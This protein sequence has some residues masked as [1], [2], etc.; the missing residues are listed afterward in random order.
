MLA[1]VKNITARLRF[2]VMNI[3]HSEPPR[4]KTG[5]GHSLHFR[6]AIY[7]CV[8]QL[9]IDDEAT[10]VVSSLG[11]DY[12]PPFQVDRIGEFWTDPALLK[13]PINHQSRY[14]D[15]QSIIRLSCFP[16]PRQAPRP[17]AADR[18]APYGVLTLR[19]R[20]F[21]CFGPD[22]FYCIL[23]RPRHMRGRETSTTGLSRKPVRSPQGN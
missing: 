6:L 1:A 11:M 5:H 4:R 21:P 22:R 23:S 12:I 2:F 17:E 15:I 8:R 9:P 10:W 14:M 7:R 18:F 3:S 20:L 16:D 19:A 13:S